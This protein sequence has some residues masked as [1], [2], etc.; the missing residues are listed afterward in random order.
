MGATTGTE[1]SYLIKTDLDGNVL[2][3]YDDGAQPTVIAG[4]LAEDPINGG[5]YM[6]ATTQ[7]VGQPIYKILGLKND[8]GTSTWLGTYSTQTD[9]IDFGNGV[10]AMPDGGAA[11]IGSAYEADTSNFRDLFLLRTDAT[12]NELWSVYFG[13]SGAETGYDV[14]VD[15]DQIVACGKAD[16]NSS[17]D[18]IIIRSDFNG[19]ANVGINQNHATATFNLY[20][21]PFSDFLNINPTS[22]IINTFSAKITDL[23]GRMLWQSSI[24]NRASV[25]LSWLPA[26]IYLF[27]AE[28]GLPKRI[29][30]M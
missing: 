17:E 10:A 24:T 16:V 14:Q 11:F 8:N 20:P 19:N 6:A 3:S 23:S 27:M 18:I 5:F 15:G 30:K 7:I 21:N 26:G 13:G 29:V 9:R 25:N 22:P 1:N 28:N 4:K 2:W 12:G